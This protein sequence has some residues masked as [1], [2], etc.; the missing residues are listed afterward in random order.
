LPLLTSI[1]KWLLVTFYC[2]FVTISLVKNESNG[3]KANFIGFPTIGP[4][5]LKKN[6]GVIE[7]T[8]PPPPSG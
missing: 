3:W 5:F 7:I 2:F 1:K 4:L 6:L 8:P